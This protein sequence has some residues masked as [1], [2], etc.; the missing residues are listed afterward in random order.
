IEIL[1]GSY[2]DDELAGDEQ[3]NV[4]RG[5]WGDDVIWGRGGN[6]LLEGDVGNDRLIGGAGADILF[7]NVVFLGYLDLIGRLLGPIG[8]DLI[9]QANDMA[10]DDPVFSAGDGFDVASY[11]TATS[12]VVASLT[13]PTINTGDAAG[14]TYILIEGLVGSAFDDTLIGTGGW[15]AAGHNTREGGAGNDTLIGLLGSGD[16]Y[17]GGAGDDT[18]VLAENRAAYTITYDAATQTFAL[19]SASSGVNHVKAVETLQF[20]DSTLS[21]ASLFAGRHRNDSLT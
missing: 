2:V 17:D 21:V 11:E 10:A 18:A 1:I 3:D 15:G 8:A 13:D 9:Q 6:D 19:T 7:G 4:L 16:D 20:A 12:G 5:S 14:D